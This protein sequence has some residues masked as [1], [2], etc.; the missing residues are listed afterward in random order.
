ML[1]ILIT[2]IDVQNQLH[3]V[4]YRLNN[5]HFISHKFGEIVRYAT[6]H[7][8]LKQ[9]FTNKVNNPKLSALYK[10]ENNIITTYNECVL[11]Y[12]FINANNDL[13]LKA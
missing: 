7:I 12:L 5:C 11:R 9:T 1:V 6:I 10:E 13:P 8:V 2:N 4:T 3:G